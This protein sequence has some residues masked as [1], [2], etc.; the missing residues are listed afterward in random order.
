MTCT[1]L[2]LVPTNEAKKYAA[3]LNKCRSYD[4][5]V[6][7]HGEDALDYRSPQRDSP[8]YAS[9]TISE[10]LRDGLKIAVAPHVDRFATCEAPL[11]CNWRNADH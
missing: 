4:P 3:Q 9:K 8:E 1:A 7:G 2:A 5:S 10:A 11:A 6:T